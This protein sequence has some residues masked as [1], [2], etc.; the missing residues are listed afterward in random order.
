M[1]SILDHVVS[2][3]PRATVYG[4]LRG[5]NV[6]VGKYFRELYPASNA[7]SY[8]VAGEREIKI[9]LASPSKT[10]F[11]DM[12]SAY[13]KFQ[14]DKVRDTTHGGNGRLAILSE[15]AG[16]SWI[17]R[18]VVKCNIAVVEDINHFNHL[19]AMFKRKILTRDQ[20]NAHSDE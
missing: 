5:T 20:K 11:Y 9:I 18:L 15:P 2:A 19:T 14:L 16:T 7:T 17:K 1:A 6:F 10:S 4:A 3:V 12:R 13:I 8:S